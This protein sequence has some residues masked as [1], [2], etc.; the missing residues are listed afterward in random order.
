MRMEPEDVDA[1]PAARSRMRLDGVSGMRLSWRCLRG[2]CR[3]GSM[4]GSWKWC[5]DV[6][7]KGQLH[8]QKQ[9]SEVP[10]LSLR[11][12]LLVP[13]DTHPRLWPF[14]DLR[15]VSVWPFW[16]SRIKLCQPL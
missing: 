13:A 10:S 7:W 6:R 8:A 1:R 2:V 4:F 9:S 16:L 12:V 3:A 5:G 14:C 15:H 11:E